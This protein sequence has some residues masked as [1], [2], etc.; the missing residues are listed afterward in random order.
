MEGRG[1]NPGDPSLTYT[2]LPGP[3]RPVPT[4]LGLRDHLRIEQ[5]R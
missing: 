5:R 1:S 3:Q 2:D 4:T